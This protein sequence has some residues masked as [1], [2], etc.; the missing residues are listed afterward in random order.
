MDEGI[1]LDRAS[2]Q[3]LEGRRL[4]RYRIR[5]KL[6]E[7]GMANVYLAQSVGEQGFERWVVVKV[8]HPQMSEDLQ[9]ATMLADEARLIARVHHPNVCSVIDF[10]Q[11][12]DLLYMV[13]EY[14]H[15]ESLQAAMRRSW[16]SESQFPAWVAARAVADA[17]RGLHAAHELTDPHGE[18]LDVVHRDVSPENIFI[19]YD[20]H[21]S[22]IDFGVVRARGR[23]TKTAAGIVKGKLS[24]MAPEQLRGEVDRRADVWSLGVVLW[25]ATL[26]RRLFRGKTQGETIENV[27]NGPITRPSAVTSNYPAELE[28]IVMA[29]LTRDPDRRT[30]TAEIL[31][32]QLE[33]YLHGLG[34]PVGQG[35]VSAWMREMFSDRLLVREALLTA[36]EDSGPISM[37]TLA[38]TEASSSHFISGTIASSSFAPPPRLQPDLTAAD[39]PS[40][41]E[42]AA[43]ARRAELR[44]DVDRTLDALREQN[45]RRSQLIWVFVA[46]ALVLAVALVY[47]VLHSAL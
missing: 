21:S 41:R 14:L 12:G 20:G 10:A 26:G 13:M 37:E 44:E 33:G 2:A 27:A 4:G 9:F 6:A 32:G 23:Q 7:G 46:I 18:L 43:A 39:A 24:H 28:R 42:A 30:A 5:H 29:A 34:R 19:T 3:N 8:V 38:D 40:S 17:A 47:F 45:R 36:P 25:E 15:G 1:Q 31:A 35:Q 11:E 22:V 16:T